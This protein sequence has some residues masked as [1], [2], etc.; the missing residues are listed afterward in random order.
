M[1]IIRRPLPALWI[2]VLA[3]CVL[4]GCDSAHVDKISDI[5]NNPSAY[6]HKDVT[7]A[8]EVTKVYEVP[9]GISDLAA[10]RV[11]D[12]SG[13]IWVLSHTGAPVVGDRVGLRGRV[14]PEGAFGGTDLGTIIEERQRR[15]RD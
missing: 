9:L 10:Y 4:A 6:A 1:T 7:V 2:L 11:N 12:G 3:L 5:A 15:V 14:R 13:Q 8:G